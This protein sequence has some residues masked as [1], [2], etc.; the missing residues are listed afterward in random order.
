MEDVHR[1][2][3]VNGDCLRS[4]LD[5]DGIGLVV[6]VEDPVWTDIWGLEGSPEGLVPYKDI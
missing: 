1:L 6:P 3:A 4:T 5:L 2:E